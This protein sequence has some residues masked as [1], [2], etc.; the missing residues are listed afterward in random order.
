MYIAVRE[1]VHHTNRYSYKRVYTNTGICGTA[2]DS[3]EMRRVKLGVRW[4]GRTPTGR[5]TVE[6][7]EDVT[8]AQLAARAAESLG[9]GARRKGAWHVVE[10]WMGC[11]KCSYIAIILSRQTP[12]KKIWSGPLLLALA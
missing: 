6:V 7:E 8:C 1:Y 2:S 5:M 9:L 3:V 4:Y 11:G 10:R 12:W